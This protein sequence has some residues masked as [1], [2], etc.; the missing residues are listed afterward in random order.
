MWYLEVLY[1]RNLEVMGCSVHV[2]SITLN[3]AFMHYVC[4]VYT[5]IFYELAGAY[6]D[7]FLRKIFSSSWIVFASVSKY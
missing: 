1:L 4:V 3:M 6:L 7:V 5:I 2:T